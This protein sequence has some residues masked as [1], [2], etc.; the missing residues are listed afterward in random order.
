MEFKRAKQILETQ[1]ELLAELNKKCEPELVA[2][3]IKIMIDLYHCLFG[4]S[5]FSSVL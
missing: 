2:T 5:N 3:N 1:M 4:S